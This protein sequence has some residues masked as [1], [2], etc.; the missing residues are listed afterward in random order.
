MHRVTVRST[1]FPKHWTLGCRDPYESNLLREG[2]SGL[3][4]RMTGVVMSPNTR[5]CR[6]S[7]H[8]NVKLGRRMSVS[9]CR[10]LGKTKLLWDELEIVR[11]REGTGE[12]PGFVGLK[13]G[14]EVRQN[15]DNRDD[16]KSYKT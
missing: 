10:A 7:T 1:G 3:E 11:L 15:K 12:I 2:K 9:Q 14:C 5:C 16:V 4:L 6:L 8:R 13:A